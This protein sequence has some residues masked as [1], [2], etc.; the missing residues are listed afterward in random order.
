MNFDLN[1][2]VR[3]NIKKL[4]PY[5]SARSEFSGK[6]RVY[7]DANENSFGSP[8]TTW[9]NRYPDPLQREVKKK[10]SAIKNVPAEQMLLGNGSDECI[11]LL[12]RAFCNPGQD[13][14]LICPPTYGMYEVYAHINDVPLKEVPLLP[15][16]QLN[17]EGMEAAID[18]ATKIIFLCS[19]NNPT[20]NSLERE[21]I[22]IVLNNFEGIV[23]VDEAYIN[24]S[25]H[26]SFLVELKDYPN[27]VVMQTFSK[28]WGLAALRLG[29]TFASQ[30]IIEVLN[31]I[32]PPYN[33]N[34]STQELVL[35]ALENLD[36]VNAMTRE[37]VKEREVLVRS[38]AQLTFVQ[39]I[40]PSDANFILVRV[41]DANSTYEYL[42][43]VGIIVRNRSNV[44]LCEGCLR[45]TVGTDFQNKELVEALNRFIPATSTQL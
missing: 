30:E 1:K 24:Y 10:I 36:D 5:S 4:K 33:I 11:D 9:Y 41:D 20:G 23:V 40:Y 38:L 35:Q 18:E 39:K 13:S 43:S 17:L 21:D 22:E 15:D 27:L 7:L 8:L 26:R 29:I 19:P 6:A 32:K 31:K 44:I 45:I 25:R 16:F 3:E 14:I 42:K 34:Q 12:I 2:L 37:T 28:A